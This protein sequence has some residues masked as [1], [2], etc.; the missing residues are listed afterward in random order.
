MCQYWPWCSAK[1]YRRTL[2]RNEKIL[3]KCSSGVSTTS[4]TTQKSYTM[5]RSHETHVPCLYFN[6]MPYNLY[7][8]YLAQEI[9]VHTTAL[10][11]SW[12]LHLLQK[13]SLCISAGICSATRTMSKT[14]IKLCIILIKNK[15]LFNCMLYIF[16]TF[17]F[18]KTWVSSHEHGLEKIRRE[19]VR[20]ILMSLPF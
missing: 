3:L 2:H 14:S 16:S 12:C 7:W 18:S 15:Y 5:Q 17:D 6:L 13:K 8:F 10:S 4:I 1:G 20:S 19:K 11:N 9:Q